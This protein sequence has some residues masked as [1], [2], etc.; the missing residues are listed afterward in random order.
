M[1]TYIV[2]NGSQQTM[3]VT[4]ITA[5]VLAAFCSFDFLV[6][7]CLFKNTCICNLALNDSNFSSWLVSEMSWL[8]DDLSQEAWD[9]FSTSRVYKR[10]YKI[11]TWFLLS[12]LPVYCHSS[13]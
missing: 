5:I 2:K 12:V 13:H 1:I 4:T 6:F 10:Q 3:K 7:F 11:Q 9:S 8:E